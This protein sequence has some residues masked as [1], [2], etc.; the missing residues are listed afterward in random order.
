MN[1]T[2]LTGIVISLVV[3]LPLAAQVEPEPEVALTVYNDNFGVVKEQRTM[4]FEEGLNTV[5]FTDVASQ[6]DPTTVNFTCL[7]APDAVTILEQNYEYDLVNTESLLKRYLDQPVTIQVKGSGGGVGTRLSGVLSASVNGELILRDPQTG[8]IHIIS[9]DSI[10]QILLE[11]KPEELVTRPTLL[12]LAAA[13]EAGPQRCRVTYT[14][15]GI[16]WQADYLATLDPN[17]DRISLSA[18]VTIDNQSGASYGDAALKLIAGDVRR[19]TPPEPPIYPQRE[20][21]AARAMDREAFEEKP[22]MEYHLYTLDRRTDIRNNQVKQIELFEPVEDI[23]VNR[24]YV[25]EVGIESRRGAEEKADVQVKIEFENT[26]A[27]RLGMP[28]PQGRVRA[29][30]LDPADETLEFVG[31]D[32]IDHTARGGKLS[33]YIGN[34][35]DVTAE[36]KL[37]DSQQG[38]GFYTY[39]REVT[40]RNSKDEDVVVFVDEQIPRGRNWTVGRSSHKYEKKDAFTIRF[41][42]PVPAGGKAVLSYQVTQTW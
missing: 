39:T 27:N 12:W 10:E 9:R 19:I 2:A 18:W 26:Q 40:V 28:L 11:K 6:I 30:K 25:A 21:M 37:T 29:F 38:R 31:E 1:R 35:F 8:Q 3:S 36:Q 16:R 24:L 14:T 4:V 15:E 17:D 41:P 32:E 22:F 33:L 5:R 23:P 42:V 20:M 34:A 13:E 7:T